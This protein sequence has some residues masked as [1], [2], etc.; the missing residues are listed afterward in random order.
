MAEEPVRHE[1]RTVK[2]V[3]GSEARTAARW[4]QEGWEVVSQSAGRLQSELLLRRPVR[5]VPRRALVIGGGAVA[6]ALVVVIVLGATGVFGHDE[7]EQR[8]AQVA[9]A[10]T[11]ESPSSAP[12]STATA[13]TSDADAV[14]TPANSPELAALLEVGNTC[15][16]AIGSFVS[17][18]AGRTISFDGSIGRMDPHEGASTRYDI[19]L[20]AGDFSTT[21]APGPAFQYRDVNTTYD[22]HYEGAVP[23]TIGAGTNLTITA[24]VD[25]YNSQQCLFQLSPVTTVV[26]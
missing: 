21:S 24:T 3:R 11:T 4:E 7:P 18:N 2:C 23:D 5:K 12:T 9:E 17:A 10:T 25:E 1:T 14:L 8:T 26:R 16:P 6:A 15:D 13:E 20:G 22:L 19:L